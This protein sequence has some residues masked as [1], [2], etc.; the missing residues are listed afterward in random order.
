MGE[1][2]SMKLTTIYE[3]VQAEVDPD[4]FLHGK[5]KHTFIYAGGRLFLQP[6]NIKHDA[7]MANRN[8]VRAIFPNGVDLEDPE[9]PGIFNRFGLQWVENPKH[10]TPE[11][12]KYAI[13]LL[14]ELHC[15]T[16]RTGMLGDELAVAVWSNNQFVADAVKALAGNP[17]TGVTA[18]TKVFASGKCIGTVQSLIKGKAEQDARSLDDYEYS[19]P[20]PYEPK[21]AR[22]TPLHLDPDKKE[23]LLAQGWR[24]KE[25]SSGLTPGQKY[26]ALNSECKRLSDI[27]LL[28]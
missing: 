11:Y 3:T 26:W 17:E 7:M 8:I 19:E 16:G 25:R 9:L 15:S 22:G 6:G 13:R 27:S 24:P 20:T 10:R 21:P 18:N 1:D 2:N 28:K 23:K 5:S 4:V 12:T 14:A